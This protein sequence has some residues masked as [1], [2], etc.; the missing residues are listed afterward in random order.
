MTSLVGRSLPGPVALAGVVLAVLGIAG[1][2]TPSGREAGTPVAASGAK[3]IH[4]QRLRRL[5]RVCAWAPMMGATAV[6]RL[7]GFDLVV[8]DGVRPKEGSV[9]TSADDVRALRRSGALVL[10][11]LSI[12]TVENWRHYAANVPDRWTL[13]PVDGWEGERYVDARV[14]GWQRMMEREARTLREAGFDGV[15]LDNVDVAEEFPETARG[16]VDLVRRLRSAAPELLIV[17]QNGLFVARQLPLDAL[18]H[19]DVWWRSTPTGYQRSPAGETTELLARL[20]DLRRKG[21]PI[22]TLDYSPPGS[23]VTRN[24]LR[25]SLREGFHPA[26]S[27]R[28]LDL[29]PHGVPTCRRA[30]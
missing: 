4:A 7:R 22:F 15:Y 26:V 3:E 19:E 2:E 25:R 10:A 20:R 5:R 9:T 17:G 14:E 23:A 18:S 21:L 29:P 1:I 6:G 24:V 27:V 13:G 8:A 28:A 11:Y 30:R 16:V 12:G